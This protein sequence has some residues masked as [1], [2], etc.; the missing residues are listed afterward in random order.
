[1][2]WV[3]LRAD[4]HVSLCGWLTAVTLCLR[5]AGQRDVLYDLRVAEEPPH[6]RGQEVQPHKQ[7]NQRMCLLIGCCC[8][9]QIKSWIC[10]MFIYVFVMFLHLCV[11]VRM[12]VYSPNELSVPSVLFAGGMAGIFNWAVAIPPD[13]LKSRFQTGDT[14]ALRTLHTHYSHVLHTHT[15]TPHRN[16]KF[17]S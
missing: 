6:S 1:M 7:T 16:R 14:H 8:N 5:R 4:W 9:K 17:T 15:R 13:V 2:Q 10:F 11:C 3:W 12:C